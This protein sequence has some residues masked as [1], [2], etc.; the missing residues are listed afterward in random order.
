[1]FEA[2]SISRT[3]FF[4][5]CFSKN[6]KKIL[7]LQEIVWKGFVM[8]SMSEHFGHSGYSR[9]KYIYLVFRIIECERSTHGSEYAE[10]IHD[11]L[12][13]VVS[14]AHSDA[15][16]VEESADVEVVNEG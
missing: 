3:H 11:G 5:F 13:A 6:N 14:G 16:T 1:M 7:S 10:T 2:L 15:E 8:L 9:R 4:G 12:R